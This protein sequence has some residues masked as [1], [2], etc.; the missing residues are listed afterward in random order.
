ML[1]CRIIT[2]EDSSSSDEEERGTVD[3][4]DQ[5]L[6]AFAPLEDCEVD[7]GR[8]GGQVID[9]N[10]LKRG[11]GG[12]IPSS[13]EDAN[14]SLPV[15]NMS[16]GSMNKKSRSS[17]ITNVTSNVVWTQKMDELLKDAVMKY[18]DNWMV[19]SEAVRTQLTMLSLDASFSSSVGNSAA[20]IPVE[21]SPPLPVHPDPME[22]MERWNQLQYE[23]V[24]TW[25]EHEVS[26]LTT[27]RA[28]AAV[29]SL[30]L[31]IQLQPQQSTQLLYPTIP[32]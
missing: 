24:P 4:D 17:E 18:Q 29:L 7:D 22:C 23:K 14:R 6:A 3:V 27:Y 15:A 20:Q 9:C 32:Y 25:T 1:S 19:I 13:S 8:G 28:E 21:V 12:G 31:C 10:P 5:I 11:L 26:R 2:G 16:M 30:T